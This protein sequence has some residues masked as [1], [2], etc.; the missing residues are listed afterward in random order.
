MASL[1]LSSRAPPGLIGTDVLE[2][3]LS[4]ILQTLQRQAADISDLK[5][6]LDDSVPRTEVAT[7]HRLLHERVAILQ[8]RIDELE[9]ATTVTVPGE[10]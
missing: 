4:G 6:R 9:A 8:A 10:A 7:A 2:T 3:A 5:A 1:L